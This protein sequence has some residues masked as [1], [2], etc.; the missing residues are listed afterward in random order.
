MTRALLSRIRALF[1]RRELDER[2]DE[3]VQSHLGELASDYVRRGMTPEAARLTPYD[4]RTI[5]IVCI[6]IAAGATAAAYLP[7]AAP[8]EWTRWSR[9]EPIRFPQNQF[10]T[11]S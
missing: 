9:C 6:V 5:A 4:G 7:P 2:L 11:D 1:R 3:E 10:Q 8:V